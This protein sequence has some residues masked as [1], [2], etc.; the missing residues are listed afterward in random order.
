MGYREAGIRPGK[1]SLFFV[2][3]RVDLERHYAEIGRHPPEKHRILC[4]VQCA[5]NGP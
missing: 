2:M 3:V 5:D 1:S 4:G